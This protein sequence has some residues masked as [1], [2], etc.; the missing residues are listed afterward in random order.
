MSFEKLSLANSQM[1]IKW[2][3][4]VEKGEE[5]IENVHAIVFLLLS[6][7]LSSDCRY[8]F[9]FGWAVWLVVPTQLGWDRHFTGIPLLSI[10]G[11]CFPFESQQV[12]FAWLDYCHK[13]HFPHVHMPV[14]YCLTV[15]THFDTL[16]KQFILGKLKSLGTWLKYPDHWR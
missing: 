15:A 8:P 5:K 7:L 10:S 9:N 11:H 13:D 4:N 12:E 6:V 1:T 14:Y 2:E 3:S 16:Y